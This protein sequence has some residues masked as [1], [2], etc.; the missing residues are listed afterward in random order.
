M[1]KLEDFMI[2]SRSLFLWETMNCMEVVFLV[3]KGFRSRLKWFLY[4]IL[5]PVQFRLHILL[6]FTPKLLSYS[7]LS[8]ASELLTF[9][10][11]LSRMELS[12]SEVIRD[13]LLCR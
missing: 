4:H 1:T 5:L 6:K 10:L 8:V 13:H 12:G 2:F 3:I 9:I 7:Q 11:M